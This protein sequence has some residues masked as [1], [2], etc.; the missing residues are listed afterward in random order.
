MKLLLRNIG[1]TWVL[2]QG[3]LCIATFSDFDAACSYLRM[4]ITLKAALD[5]L[6][7]DLMADYIRDHLLSRGAPVGRA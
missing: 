6:T 5:G 2:S 1:G 7:E 3:T 4:P